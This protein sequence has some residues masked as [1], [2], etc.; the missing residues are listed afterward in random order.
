MTHVISA[1][2]KIYIPSTVFSYHPY[3][4]IS[5]TSYIPK[6]SI[7]LKISLALGLVR[8]MSNFL[9]DRV[10]NNWESDIYDWKKEIAVV[11]GGSSGFGELVTLDL[12]RRGVKVVVVDYRGT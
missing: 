4:P 8:K 7:A 5:T 6:V 2:Y 10:L 1:A 12:G 11:K 3:I 9:S